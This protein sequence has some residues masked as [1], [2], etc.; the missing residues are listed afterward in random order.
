VSRTRIPA[1]LWSLV[2]SRAVGF[3]EYCGIHEDDAFEAHEADH[4][5]AEQHGGETTAENLAFACWQCNRR[6]G[7]NLS[8]IDP[9]SRE[10]VRLFHPRQDRWREHFRI[11]GARIVT[12]TPIGRATA[13]L[14]RLNSPENLILRTAL[15]EGGRYPMR[16]P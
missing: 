11:E 12:L 1:D 15:C 13:G 14:L 8:S 7:P 4:I 5:I 2:Q 16:G 9:E 10:I 3:C 6:K